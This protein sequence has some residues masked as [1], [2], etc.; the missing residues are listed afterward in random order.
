[1]ARTSLSGLAVNA[2]EEEL[3]EV[4]AFCR[5]Q[6]VGLEVTAFAYPANLDEGYRE[7]VETHAEALGDVA[8]LLCHGPFLDL[9]PTSPDPRVVAVARDR[10]EANRTSLARLRDLLDAERS[11]T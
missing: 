6:G 9:Y 3:T 11:L 2:L 5:E 8:P 4:A 1:M 7:R 10:H